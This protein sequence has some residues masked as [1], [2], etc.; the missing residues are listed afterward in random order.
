MSR[1]DM[2]EKTA[3]AN[4]EPPPENVGRMKENP[5]ETSEPP[6]ENGGHQKPKVEPS[7]LERNTQDFSERPMCL[8]TSYKTK[9]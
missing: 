8:D 4:I 9:Q 7:I 5:S 1:S 6:P 2:A 3:K